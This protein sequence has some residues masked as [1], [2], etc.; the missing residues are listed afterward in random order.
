MDQPDNEYLDVD[1]EYIYDGDDDIK[2]NGKDVGMC[3]LGLGWSQRTFWQSA[4]TIAMHWVGVNLLTPDREPF[5][6][7]PI[8]AISPVPVQLFIDHS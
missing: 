6:K 4:D 2:D 1:N 5:Q 3:K 8:C 7:Q